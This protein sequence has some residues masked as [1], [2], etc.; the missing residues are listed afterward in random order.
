MQTLGLIEIK[1]EIKVEITGVKETFWRRQFQ[2][3]ATESQKK[4]DWI[5]GIIL[6]VA[7]FAFDPAIFK[8]S[9]LWGSNAYLG[10][11]KPFAYL[12]SF[13]SVMTLMAFMIW[14][15]KLKWLNAF[16]AGFFF[17]G[18][19]VSLGIGVVLL[20]IS[21]LGLIILIGALGFTPLFTA[22]VYLRNAVRSYKFAKSHLNK[23]VLI[24]TAILAALF[25]S[26]T[27]AVI[28]FEI[29]KTL[30][31]IKTGDSQTIRANADY[32]YFV[33]PIV[34]F[35][36]LI[37]EYRTEQNTNSK[38]RKA[39][40]DVYKKLTGEKIETQHRSPSIF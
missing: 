32:L 40:S 21:L 4:F 3:E 2:K 5:F 18:G 10:S 14:G 22:F 6:P 16:L 28:N 36:S 26:I 7:C 34:N 38:R 37:L 13:L 25:G 24:Q 31:E 27:P 39:L 33:A 35:D 11:I 30:S 20:P 9:D 19:L 29:D 1:D 15:V 12:L 8:T 17:I 23:R